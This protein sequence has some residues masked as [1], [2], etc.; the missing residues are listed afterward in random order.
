M[1]SLYLP[2][3]F[4]E[5]NEEFIMNVFENI[6][7][8]GKV[9]RVD[10]VSNQPTYNSVYVHFQYW[11]IEQLHVR[12]F[13]EHIMEKKSVQIVYQGK[14]YWNVNLNTSKG[15]PN[16]VNK[17][18]ECVDIIS[19]GSKETAVKEVTMKINKF[20]SDLVNNQSIDCS[21]K[22]VNFVAELT[23]HDFINI[24]EIEAAQEE[25]Y[26]AEMFMDEIERFDESYFD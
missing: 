10:I 9:S 24:D 2:H 25:D 22:T 11:N 1:L 8:F 21:K 16:N 18:N 23:L 6:H 14:Y 15:K 5:F 7:K 19:T 26:Y 13:Q 20:F 12:E 4:P 3:V 17:R